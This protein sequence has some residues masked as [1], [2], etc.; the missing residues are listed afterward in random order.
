MNTFFKR[1][2]V[3][4]FAFVPVCLSASEPMSA[5]L[6]YTQPVSFPTSGTRTSIFVDNKTSTEFLIEIPGF[7]LQIVTAGQSMQVFAISPQNVAIG[8]NTTPH[9]TFKIIINGVDITIDCWSSS[10]GGGRGA[11]VRVNNSVYTERNAA[12]AGISSEHYKTN[13]YGVA[14]DV[15]VQVYPYRDRDIFNADIRIIIKPA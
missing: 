3:V 14:Y 4:G 6:T 7:D 10:F 15:E 1:L 9:F 2:L 13:V 12:V 8:R 11:G 5:Q